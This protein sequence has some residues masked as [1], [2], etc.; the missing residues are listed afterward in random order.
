VEVAPL[1]YIQS[2]QVQVLDEEHEVCEAALQALQESPTV[3]N[4]KAVLQVY[5]DHFAHEEALLDEHMWPVAASG[6]SAGG[7]DADANARK[8]HFAD[9]GR[10]LANIRAVLMQVALGS[11]GDGGDVEIKPEFVNQVLR[12]FEQHANKYD[13]MYAQRLSAALAPEEVD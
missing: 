6:K 4:A 10:M 1:A 7:F 13:V 8:S 12:D 3:E 2:V 11:S 9:H 5:S